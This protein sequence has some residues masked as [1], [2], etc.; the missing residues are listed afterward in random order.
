MTLSEFLE[1]KKERTQLPSEQPLNRYYERGQLPEDKSN[2]ININSPNRSVGYPDL[3]IVY[4]MISDTIAE[5]NFNLTTLT[6]GTAVIPSSMIPVTGVQLEE[7]NPTARRLQSMARSLEKV[8][9]NFADKSLKT[10]SLL[11]SKESS[12]LY[13]KEASNIKGSGLAVDGFQGGKSSRDRT[14]LGVAPNRG[15]MAA[16]A[17][18]DNEVFRKVHLRNYWKFQEDKPLRPPAFTQGSTSNAY[19]DLLNARLRGATTAKEDEKRGFLAGYGLSAKEFSE[20]MLNDSVINSID[21]NHTS[22][23]DY[24]NAFYY[25]IE[26]KR[27]FIIDSGRF[28][29]GAVDNAWESPLGTIGPN[30][31]MRAPTVTGNI[32]GRITLNISSFSADPA[33]TPYFRRQLLSLGNEVTWGNLY[34]DP[35][36]VSQHGFDIKMINKSSYSHLTRPQFSW[37]SED[38]SRGDSTKT[39]ISVLAHRFPDF[40]GNMSYVF[41]ATS[42]NVVSALQAGVTSQNII[43]VEP[44]R[45]LDINIKM[46]EAKVEQFS[47]VNREISVLSGAINMS[48]QASIKIRLDENLSI[49]NK[50][51]AAAGI[52]LGDDTTVFDSNNRGRI[53]NHYEPRLLNRP[54]VLRNTPAK[55][56]SIDGVQY[57]IELETDLYVAYNLI[58][59]FLPLHDP[60]EASTPYSLDVVNYK[61]DDTNVLYSRFFI[62]R[63]VRFLGVPDLEL[64][65]DGANTD[66]SFNFTFKTIEEAEYGHSYEN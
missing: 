32:H 62:F 31:V 27:D 64:S 11:L 4:D 60:T 7:G 57:G 28:T 56:V 20:L 42:E 23:E 51:F 43:D 50:V 30:G 12:E 66:M 13:N 1:N 35:R 22:L 48:H 2:D 41:F 19:K 34:F 39:A 17:P 18:I 38:D 6:K 49:Y 58:T 5:R 47:F 45:I 65:K 36:Y 24:V 26:A 61:H 54:T 14:S 37:D 53:K 10:L 40:M 29:Y 33:H 21:E 8:D 25:G 46:P 15:T 63:G 3:N 16:G 9:A 52:L 59:N 55:M 44:A